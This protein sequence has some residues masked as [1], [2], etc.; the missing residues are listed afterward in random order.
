MRHHRDKAVEALTLTECRELIKIL[1]NQKQQL[2]LRL[3]QTTVSRNLLKDQIK[4]IP[5]RVIVANLE[6]ISNTISYSEVQ[7]PTKWG[8]E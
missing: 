3:A 2:E 4:P 5:W 6:D 7:D 1:R 8:K